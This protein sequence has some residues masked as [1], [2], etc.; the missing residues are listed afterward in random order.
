VEAW[1]SAGTRDVRVHGRGRPVSGAVA[2]PSCDLVVRSASVAGL[3][4]VDLAARGGR[5]VSIEPNSSMVG[6]RELNANGCLTTPPLVDSHVH[7]DSVLTAGRPRFNS[8]GTLFEGIAIWGEL[9]ETLTPEDVV[10]RAAEV[11]RWSVAQGTLFI[12]T[13]ADVSAKNK[14]PLEGLLRLRDDVAD[15]AT[16]QVT[17][18][19]Q[20]GIYSDADNERLLEEAVGA[21][22][23]CIGGIPHFEPTSELGLKEVKRVF[24]LAADAGCLIDI[25][26]DETDD[27][28]SRFLEVVADLT[29]RYEMSG[30]VTASHCTAMGSYEP[31]YSSKVHALLARAGVSVV[32]NPFA[33]SLIQ[34]R[35]DNYPKRRGFAQM[36]ELL[37]AGVNVAI[38]NDVVMD[39]W[40]LMG[41]ADA[42]QAAWLALHFTY[43]SGL[44]EI[45]RLLDCVTHCGAKAL[46][47]GD[48]YGL[49]VGRPADCVVFDALDAIEA[50]RLGA[51]R[52]YVVRGGAVVAETLPGTSTVMGTTVDFRWPR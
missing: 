38:G 9:K 8:S 45:P 26:C 36:K 4:V 28:N 18:F 2:L 39:P 22:V 48:G 14:A 6:E 52:R 35:L 44:E 49:E 41:R 16:I 33:N 13:H 25:H 11:V 34:G 24:E 29:Q 23:D 15:L 5:W 1:L 21:G 19:P 46:A 43:M 12:R 47:L 3:G 37:A 10:S 17:A 30:R 51:A 32:V 42:L 7:L 40:Y 31:Y 50:L 20:D 27:P